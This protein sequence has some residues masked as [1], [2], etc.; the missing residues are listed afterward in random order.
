ML[1]L[2][3]VAAIVAAWVL[4]GRGSSSHVAGR[5]PS[6]AG[7]SSV[8]DGAVSSPVA[9]AGGSPLDQSIEMLRQEYQLA[10]AMRLEWLSRTADAETQLTDEQRRRLL[11]V[12]QSVARM[13]EDALRPTQAEQERLR[14]RAEAMGRVGGADEEEVLR[15]R[16]EL[17]ALVQ[18]RQGIADELNRQYVEMLSRELTPEQL[19]I[20]L[21]P[22]EPAEAPREARPI[23]PPSFEG[24]KGAPGDFPAAG[25]E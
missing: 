19:R 2:A 5:G 15:V 4:L 17:W 10:A 16:Q 25:S 1:A 12:N 13:A 9:V 8:S 18:R 6:G 14:L 23:A 7:G 20:L 22:P 3:G 11:A 21:E 24:A